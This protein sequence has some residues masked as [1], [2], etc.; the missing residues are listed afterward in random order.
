MISLENANMLEKIVQTTEYSDNESPNFVCLVKLE[1]GNILGV[2]LDK[3][4]KLFSSDL[5]L[6]KSVEMTGVPNSAI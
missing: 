5:K 3:K 2:G 4:L 6:L 1:N